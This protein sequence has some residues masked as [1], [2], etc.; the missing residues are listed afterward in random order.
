[1][2]KSLV[3]VSDD[4]RS[5]VAAD[6]APRN[7]LTSTLYHKLSSTLSANVMSSQESSGS[8]S[9]SPSSSDTS[10]FKRWSR[11]FGVITGIGMNEEERSAELEAHHGR[12]CEAWK[13]EM[14]N[15]SQY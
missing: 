3:P 5:H 10:I 11:T 15:Y 1:M 8:S 12:T 2:K 14:M 4:R 6:Q 9:S 7:R 13:R